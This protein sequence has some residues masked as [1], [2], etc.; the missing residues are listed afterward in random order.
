MLVQPARVEP[1]AL[2][3]QLDDHSS[4]DD[5]LYKEYIHLRSMDS[6]APTYVLLRKYS[7]VFVV[8]K[9]FAFVC[10]QYYRSSTRT[11]VP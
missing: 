2:L 10:V 8:I 7:G 9:L 1:N 11:T 6:R 5:M 4:N 3:G